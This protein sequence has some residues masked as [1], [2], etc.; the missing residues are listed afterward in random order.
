MALRKGRGRALRRGRGRT[1]G[2][3]RG[4][5]LGRGRGRALR[6]YTV[7]MFLACIVA[8]IGIGWLT[9]KGNLEAARMTGGNLKVENEQYASSLKEANWQVEIANQK[10]EQANASLCLLNASTEELKQRLAESEK[11]G[12]YWWERAHPREFESLDELKAWL[13]KD[14]T[15]KT[16]YIFGSGCLGAYDCDDYAVALVYNAFLDGYSIS[17]QVEG[18]HMLN[19]TIIG[20]R[21]YFIEPQNDKV[22][23]WGDRD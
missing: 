16:I 3:G 20:D 4:R 14:D 15:D 18:N 22:W 19:S 23:L 10:I 11:F 8:G 13:A 7:L 21:I 17:L 9:T 6:I 1:L 12:A 2:R 5:T